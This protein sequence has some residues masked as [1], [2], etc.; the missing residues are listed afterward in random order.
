[1]VKEKPSGMLRVPR[2]VDGEKA[3]FAQAAFHRD[4]AAVGLGDV[5][6]DGQAQ[7]RP[8]QIAAASLVDAVEPLEQARKVLARHSRAV[9]QH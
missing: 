3:A 9:V 8:A 1:M 6:D 5:L 2:Q 4:V 7:A